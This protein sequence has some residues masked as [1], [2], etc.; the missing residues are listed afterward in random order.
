MHKANIED[1]I[2]VGITL[3]NILIIGM[4]KN[5]YIAESPIK[6]KIPKK[7]TGFIPKVASRRNIS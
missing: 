7:T 5:A 4:P 6:L 3:A 2:A 1:S